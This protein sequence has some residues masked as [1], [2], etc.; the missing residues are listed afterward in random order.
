MKKMMSRKCWKFIICRNKHDT[1]REITNSGQTWLWKQGNMACLLKQ[2]KRLIGF[3]LH[4]VRELV[5]LIEKFTAVRFRV[6]LVHVGTPF[7]TNWSPFHQCP[8]LIHMVSFTSPSLSFYFLL[9][10]AR[11]ETYLLITSFCSRRLFLRWTLSKS[12]TVRHK[13][14]WATFKLN[15]ILFLCNNRYF[16]ILVFTKY[17]FQI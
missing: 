4:L 12:I 13:L 10:F 3:V 11:T 7:I 1:T 15:E 6:N 2:W 17:T 9:L 14:Q 8:R 16:E 5:Q